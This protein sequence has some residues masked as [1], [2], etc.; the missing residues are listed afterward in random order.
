MRRKKLTIPD[1]TQK[2]F[3]V[4]K[5]KKLRKMQQKTAQIGQACVQFCKTKI[6]H[7]IEMH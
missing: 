6:P 2:D 4:F 1:S 7:V 5:C 3:L